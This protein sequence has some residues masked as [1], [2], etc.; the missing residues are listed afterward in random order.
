MKAVMRTWLPAGD[1][2]FQMIVVHLPSPVTAQRYRAANL[3]EG[4][5]DDAVSYM[6]FILGLQP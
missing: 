2:M 4:P 6:L 5:A 1:A 3:Y